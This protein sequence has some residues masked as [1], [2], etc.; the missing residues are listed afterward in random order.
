[1]RH[2]L[3]FLTF[4]FAVSTLQSCS[5]K[6]TDN[7]APIKPNTT[8]PLK[9][10]GFSTASAPGDHTIIITGTGFSTIKSENIVTFNNKPAVVLEA[11]TTALT[12]SVPIAAGTG[13]ITVKSGI[14]TATS[15]DEFNFIYTVTTIAGNGTYGFKDGKGAEAAFRTPYG[16]ATDAAGNVYVADSDNNK[17]RKITADGTV[18]TIAGTGII[19]SADGAAL[20]AQFNYPHGLVLDATGNIYV[21]D[22]GNN[23]IR[24]ITPAGIVSTVA[25]NGK[26]GLVNGPA[27]TAEFNF[28]AGITL[29]QA[30]NL[31]VADGTNKCIRKITPDGIVSTFTESSFGFPEGIVTDNTGNL[32]VA[33]AASNVIRKVTPNGTVSTYAGS[34]PG[35]HDGAAADAKFAN[36]EGIAVDAA[37][38][39]YIGDLSNNAVRKIT[40]AGLVSTIAGATTR[41]Y[42]EG[43]G[44]NA[45]FSNPS[46]ITVA[47]SGIVYLGDIDNSRIRKLQ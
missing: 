22:A 40:P 28:P 27:A 29:D 16:L 21:A 31:Y 46:G 2:F 26:V 44:T 12:V 19:G 13:K 11:T 3:L 18:T 37:G 34:I 33:D 8:E 10:T 32:Y 41:G 30:G 25:G 39:L 20:I 5:K 43:Q 35:Y 4:L 6:N 45:R 9:I 14:Q 38:N 17:I 36:P 23:M 24:K 42:L 1:M 15:G 7:T 47:P